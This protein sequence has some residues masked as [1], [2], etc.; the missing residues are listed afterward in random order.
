[1]RDMLKITAAAVAMMSEI[2]MPRYYAA[3]NNTAKPKK[4][5]AKVKAA[6]KQNRSRK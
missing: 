1:M 6:R 2:P 5:R 3:A 4:N